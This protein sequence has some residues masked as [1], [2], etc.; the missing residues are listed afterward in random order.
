MAFL[1]IVIPTRNESD[2]IVPLVR[3]IEKN[4]QDH[5]Y[6][7]VFVDDSTDDTPRSI[8]ASTMIPKRGRVKVIHRE[9]SNGL[10]GAILEDRKSVV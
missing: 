4:L 8:S 1:S 6:E 2:N 5:I 3:E 10:S 7:I 9:K